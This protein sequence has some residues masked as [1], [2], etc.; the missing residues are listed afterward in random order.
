MQQ[1]YAVF[2][3]TGLHR[4]ADEDG[5]QVEFDEISLRVFL[6]RHLAPVTLR[7]EGY[8]VIRKDVQVS[9]QA[10]FIQNQ[11]QADATGQ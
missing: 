2:A 3:V 11:L 9:R 4:L 8:A 7:Y 10:I 5:R 6:R 1:R